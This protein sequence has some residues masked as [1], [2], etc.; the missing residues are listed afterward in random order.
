MKDLDGMNCTTLTLTKIKDVPPPEFV[1]PAFGGF[2]Y[3]FCN[4]ISY[5]EEDREIREYDSK[6]RYPDDWV[7]EEYNF[8]TLDCK[9]GEMEDVWF[10]SFGDMMS[11]LGVGII[12][13]PI[14]S[15]LQHMARVSAIF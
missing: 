13:Q 15:F 5:D 11:Q 8:T 2:Q 14:V 7:Y 1:P 9:N 3:E 12:I 10:V 6:P 4:E